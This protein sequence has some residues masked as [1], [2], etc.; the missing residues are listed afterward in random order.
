MEEKTDYQDPFLNPRREFIKTAAFAS[1]SVLATFWAYDLCARFQGNDEVAKQRR[2]QFAE[3]MGWDNLDDERSSLYEPFEPIE[4]HDGQFEMIGVSHTAQ[5]LHLHQEEMRAKVAQAPFVFSEYFSPGVQRVARLEVTYDQLKAPENFHLAFFGGLGKM[6][7][8][9]GKD[10]VITNPQNKPSEL[11]EFYLAG[12]IPVGL[13]G[14]GLVE[15]SK[16]LADLFKKRFTRRQILKGMFTQV[17]AWALVKALAMGPTAAVWASWE[18]YTQKVQSALV[19]KGLI[20]SDLP[21]EEQAQLLS[22]YMV[23]WRDVETAEGTDKAMSLYAGEISPSQTAPMFQGYGHGGMNEYLKN[24]DLRKKKLA[25]YPHYHAV[26]ETSIRRYSH[27]Q[28]S[29]TWKLVQKV[30]Y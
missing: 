11:L 26:G 9:Q 13:T 3:W 14:I 19:E 25:H 2:R 21:P 20:N 29:D 22:W 7:A 17:P 24:P 27:D 23:D 16:L 30:D 10:I 6:C 18:G 28:K 5:T 12:G 4:L 15:A 1:A 8:E